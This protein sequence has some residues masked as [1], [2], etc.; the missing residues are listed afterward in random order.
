M[1]G[2]SSDPVGQGLWAAGLEFAAVQEFRCQLYT[3]EPEV[4]VEGDRIYVGAR[5]QLRLSNGRRVGSHLTI[6]N[7]PTCL[8]SQRQ[9][10]PELAALWKTRLVA[11]LEMLFEL[12][13]GPPIADQRVCTETEEGRLR[14]V[15]LHRVLLE[16]NVH[17]RMA[18]VLGE[19]RRDVILHWPSIIEKNRR[20]NQF[21]VSLDRFLD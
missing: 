7:G 5:F 2:F 10:S 16:C 14:E 18:T 19:L 15:Y 3:I 17:K 21:H 12:G 1:E 9:L 11:A 13:D 4:K 6:L 20:G 8:S